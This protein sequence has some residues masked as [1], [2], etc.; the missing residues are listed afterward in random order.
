MVGLTFGDKIPLTRLQW[1]VVAVNTL[2]MLLCAYQTTTR[3]FHLFGAICGVILEYQSID[4]RLLTSQPIRYV[5]WLQFVKTCSL[6]SYLCNQSPFLSYILTKSSLLN[7]K[8]GIS[9]LSLF[10]LSLL[11]MR[12]SYLLA[13]TPLFLFTR[14]AVL[15]DSFA[16]ALAMIGMLLT[17][18]ASGFLIGA[19]AI[20]KYYYV[21]LIPVML[22]RGQW[23]AG[24]IASICVGV[25][26]TWLRSTRLWYEQTR[27][28]RTLAAS[29]ATLTRAYCVNRVKRFGFVLCYLFPILCALNL[30]ILVCAV[31]LFLEFAQ[32]KYYL[33]LWC[34]WQ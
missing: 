4:E 2:T 33:L 19:A 14:S 24:I 9:L 20:T 15:H 11:P 30:S 6:R 5:T 25:Y 13:A 21:L 23:T 29:R 18:V 7:M 16:F 32:I 34:L 22:L 3:F 31:L 17:G 26:L 28:L 12:L 10:V 27:F 8:I 1:A